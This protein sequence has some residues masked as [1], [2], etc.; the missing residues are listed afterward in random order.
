MTN[1]M[2]AE[3]EFNLLFVNLLKENPAVDKIL[4]PIHQMSILSIT[5]CFPTLCSFSSVPPM[6]SSPL[7]IKMEIS[8]KRHRIQHV[9]ILGMASVSN[10]KKQKGKKF[11]SFLRT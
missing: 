2:K 6:S 9:A 8:R 11:G 3:R 4:G 10:T 1:N 5:P 7:L